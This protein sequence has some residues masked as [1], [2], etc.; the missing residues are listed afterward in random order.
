M[1]TFKNIST[2]AIMF[3]I[4]KTDY[5]V[6]PG[7]TSSLPSDNQYVQRLVKQSMLEEV[8]SAPVTNNKSTETAK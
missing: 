5:I 3:S 4:G 1:K 2:I 8:A 7:A 6:H